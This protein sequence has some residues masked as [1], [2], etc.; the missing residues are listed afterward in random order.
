MK[1]YGSIK[2]SAIVALFLITIFT[3]CRDNFEFDEINKLSDSLAISGS[4]GIP[5]IETSASLNEFDIEQGDSSFWV[6]IDDNNLIHL[7][8]KLNALQKQL[9]DVYPFTPVIQGIPIVPTITDFE[10]TDKL[11]LGLF[12]NSIAG[13]FFVADPILK[14]IIS[15]YVGLT[16]NFTINSFDFYD[17]DNILLGTI[18]NAPINT[19]KTLAF[20]TTSGQYEI[21]ELLLNK[22]TA[23]NFPTLLSQLPN[24]IGFKSSVEIPSQTAPFA[25]SGDTKLNVD[26]EGDIPVD[27]WLKDFILSDT[28]DLDLTA[29][30]TDLITKLLL[31]IKL[32]NGFP[33]NAKTQFYFASADA[34]DNAGPIIDSVWTTSAGAN[35]LN[36][37]ITD[38][39]GK[40]T[41][42]TETYTEVEITYEKV[43]KLRE[44]GAKKLIFSIK[45][46]TYNVEAQQ[47]I[48]IYSDYKVDAKISLK[49]D[50]S[51]NSSSL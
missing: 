1:N 14:I 16:C 15:N 40:V 45:L 34:S 29:N 50:Y 25:M 10:P 28:I 33:I 51:A 36:A 17:K 49:A 30:N 27:F 41:K 11:V 37:A 39:N 5:L 12:D 3:S 48:K 38:T 32:N 23:P 9:S 22:T 42:A 13:K 6:E 24:S 21:T 18:E 19:K 43:K 4:L 20:P 44:A 47:N 7:K 26:I 31:K 46:N 35:L 2:I 8:F